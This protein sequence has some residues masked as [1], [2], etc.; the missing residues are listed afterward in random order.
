MF[1]CNIQ[2][3]HIALYYCSCFA[4]DILGL[5]NAWHELSFKFKL[6]LTLIPCL[7]SLTS[8][9]RIV[10]S[11]WDRFKAVGFLSSLRCGKNMGPWTKGS[12]KTHLSA[13]LILLAPIG[14]L[15]I[16]GCSLGE[17]E[18]RKDRSFSPLRCNQSVTDWSDLC[19]MPPWTISEDWTR[20]HHRSE[21]NN[22]I[23]YWD[24]EEMKSRGEAAT[25]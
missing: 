12:I 16:L 24:K 11:V 14:E 17:A 20:N 6:T 15:C 19:L 4:R 3:L 23:R 5:L 9:L 8:Q 7:L 18:R 13:E 2:M 10:T 25:C 1:A 22:T 21:L